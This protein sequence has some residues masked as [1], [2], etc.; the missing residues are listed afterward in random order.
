MKKRTIMPMLAVIVSLVL[1]IGAV[2]FTGIHSN[3][4]AVNTSFHYK[5]PNPLTF[6]SLTN[7]DNWDMT[8]PSCPGLTYTCEISTPDASSVPGLVAYISA[9]Y[10]TN[11]PGA[12]TYVVNKTTAKQD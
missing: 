11:H 3:E 5:G 12:V 9:N 10:S 8:S 7:K 4:T 1:T 6:E 2:A